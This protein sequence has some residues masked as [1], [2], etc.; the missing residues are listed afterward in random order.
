MNARIPKSRRIT[1]EAEGGPESWSLEVEGRELRL[2]NL[3]KEFYPGTGFT[4][5]DMIDYYAAIA[6]AL[7]PHLKDRPITLRRFPGGVDHE[8]WWEKHSPDHRPRWVRTAL[9][10]SKTRGGEK[11]RYT[12]INDLPTLLWAANLAAIELHVSLARA[13]SRMTPTSMVY[14]L[15]PGEPAD[16][17]DCAEIALIIRDTLEHQGLESFAKVSGSK[18]VQL[19]V[20]LNGRTHYDKTGGYAHELAKVFETQMPDRVVSRMKKSLRGG[21][22]LID[23]SQN[24]RHKT[25]VA[26]YSLRAKDEPFVSAPVEWHELERAVDRSD[27]GSLYFSPRQVAQRVARKGDLFAPVLEIEQKL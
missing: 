6:P 17:I 27:P 10:E 15:D 7:L 16:I 19:Y 25:T 18:G 8:G 13:R 14:D 9:I 26:V 5:G 21:K 22:V 1:E 12:M 4:K 23:W 11:V 24:S 20:P 2:S 3:D